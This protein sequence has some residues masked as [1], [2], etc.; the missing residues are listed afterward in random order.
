[1]VVEGALLQEWKDRSSSV[2][3]RGDFIH[4]PSHQ[5][6]QATCVSDAPCMILLYSD[7]LWD[8]H[9]VDASGKEISVDEAVVAATKKGL[10]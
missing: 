8:M 7:D 3:K 10:K 5:V 9:F 6:N 2:A 1:M 4:I